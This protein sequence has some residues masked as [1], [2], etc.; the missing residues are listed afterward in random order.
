MWKRMQSIFAKRCDRP[1]LLPLPLVAAAA[2]SIAGSGRPLYSWRL[3][4]A[5]NC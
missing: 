4:A 2:A 3:Q 5:A 1:H